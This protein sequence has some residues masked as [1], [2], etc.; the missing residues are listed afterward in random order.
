MECSWGRICVGIDS[1]R[2]LLLKKVAMRFIWH[3][4]LYWIFIVED[5]EG[6]MGDCVKLPRF[7]W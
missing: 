2:T 3:H 6:L 1:Q 7:L 5:K 4:W